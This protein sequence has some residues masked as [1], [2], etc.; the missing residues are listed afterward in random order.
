M[1]QPA[2][3]GVT[4]RLAA[5]SDAAELARLI[6][7]FDHVKVTPEQVARRLVAIQGV[8]T[9]VLAETS[10]RVVGFASLRI[11]PSLTDEGLYAELTE[12]YV[13]AAQRRRGIGRALM[14]RVEALARGQGATRLVLLT[15][16]RNAAAQAFY[17]AVGYADYALAMRKRL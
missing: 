5:A 9:V 7:A 10:G 3:E 12:L 4:I 11:V 6:E 1:C 16:L 8:E 13:E 17:R 15:G 2:E 14:A